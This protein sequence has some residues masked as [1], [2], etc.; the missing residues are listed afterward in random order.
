MIEDNTADCISFSSFHTKGR[1]KES[2]LGPLSKDTAV[3]GRWVF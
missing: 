3:S 2:S 1:R